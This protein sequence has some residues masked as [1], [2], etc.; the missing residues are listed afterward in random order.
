MF[1]IVSPEN[2]FWNTQFCIEEL[3]ENTINAL[4]QLF[5]ISKDEYCAKE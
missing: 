2:T 4:I 5:E 3:N 1:E